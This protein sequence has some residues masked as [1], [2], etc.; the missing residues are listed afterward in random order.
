M[1]TEANHNVKCY[2]C[3][4]T[5]ECTPGYK[6]NIKGDKC[7]KCNWGFVKT[8]NGNHDCEPCPND[9]FTMIRGA[10]KKLTDCKSM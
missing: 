10:S 4:F 9:K 3:Y 5:A 7:K 8:Q 6:L 1:L 2:F